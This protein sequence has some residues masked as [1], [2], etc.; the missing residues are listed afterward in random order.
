M[1]SVQVSSVL[2]GKRNEI[3][4]FLF[5][6]EAWDRG[7][8]PVFE[9]E[10]LQSGPFREKTVLKWR[11]SRFGVSFDWA[12]KIDSIKSDD[13]MIVSQVTGPFEEWVLTQELIDHGDQ[14]TKI[15]DTIQYKLPLGIVGAL[16]D[17]LYARRE[18]KKLLESRHEKIL[19]LL[20][21]RK[22]KGA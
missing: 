21:N 18:L 11:L 15:K 14:A 16:I 6:E 13:R 17:D 2:P 5:R 8:P 7:I 3:F 4:D 9:S 19:E 10:L 20:Q 22:V 1:P 12:V